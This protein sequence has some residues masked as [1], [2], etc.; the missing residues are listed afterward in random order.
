MISSGNDCTV[1]VWRH[2]ESYDGFDELDGISSDDVPD[3]LPAAVRLEYTREHQFLSA[4]T[5]A[6]LT[7][8]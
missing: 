8:L 1:R 6:Y 4:D 2:L 7:S 3:S 5:K